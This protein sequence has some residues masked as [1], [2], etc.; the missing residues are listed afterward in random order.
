MATKVRSTPAEASKKWAEKLSA[1]TAEIERGVMKVE[2]APGISA[3]AQMQKYL[4]GV[5]ENATKWRTNVSRVGLGEWQSSMKSLGIPRIAQGAT[6]KI[7]KMESF[8]SEF[9]PHLEQV[10]QKVN[11]MPSTTKAQRIQRAVAQMEGAG[12]FVRGKAGQ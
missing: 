4:T 3:A 7:G 9:F 11:N 10:M 12:T 5:Q 8:Q 1:A 6:Q 2:V